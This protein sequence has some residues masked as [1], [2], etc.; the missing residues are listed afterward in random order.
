MGVAMLDVPLAHGHRGLP[1]EG[2]RLLVEAYDGE[3]EP[4]EHNDENDGEL[5][6]R[7]L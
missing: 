5:E 2:P 3:R 4:D 7:L 1:R 6:E